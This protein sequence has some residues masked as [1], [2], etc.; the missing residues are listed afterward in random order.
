MEQPLSHRACA[1]LGRANDA[2]D[3]H[4]QHVEQDEAEETKRIPCDVIRHCL[5]AFAE[6]AAEFCIKLPKNKPISS[7]NSFVPNENLPLFDHRDEDCCNDG[8]Q[9]SQH[10]EHVSQQ[11]D[12]FPHNVKR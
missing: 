2:M 9:P 12:D 5:E 8:T 6:V 10:E 1:K 11:E 4:H 7:I 3:G